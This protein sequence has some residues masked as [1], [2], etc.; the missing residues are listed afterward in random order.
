MTVM[1]RTPA[2]SRYNQGDQLL[3]QLYKYYNGGCQLTSQHSNGKTQTE[4]TKIIEGHH[5]TINQI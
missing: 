4:W 5:T 3:T 2:N 1:Y